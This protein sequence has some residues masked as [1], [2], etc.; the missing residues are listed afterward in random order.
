M[1]SGACVHLSRGLYVHAPHEGVDPVKFVKEI[2]QRHN[3]QQSKST[4]YQI[5][6]VPVSTSDADLFTKAESLR[7]K[8]RLRTVQDDRTNMTLDFQSAT[9][10]QVQKQLT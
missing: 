6:G 3:P 5:L 4:V 9:S 10:L 1:Q 2:L 7:E 8:W